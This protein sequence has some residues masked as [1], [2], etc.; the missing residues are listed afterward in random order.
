VSGEAAVGHEQ[1]GPVRDLRREVARPGR[2]KVGEEDGLEM[3]EV[4]A[5]RAVWQRQIIAMD[6]ALMTDAVRAAHSRRS[7]GSWW[8]RSM[9]AMS[10]TARWTTVV[11]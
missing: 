11:A 5:H 6:A 8:R 7:W 3:G 1:L 4:G 10:T 2:D 9:S